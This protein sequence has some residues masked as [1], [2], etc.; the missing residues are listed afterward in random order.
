MNGKKTEVMVKI[1]SGLRVVPTTT[2]ANLESLESY[3]KYQDIE[4]FAQPSKK[5]HSRCEA[6]KWGL[7]ISSVSLMP[8][9]LYC[10][11]KYKNIVGTTGKSQCRRVNTSHGRDTLC[12]CSRM[13]LI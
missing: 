4:E 6:L 12:A 1:V 11:L 8:T 9:F 10:F 13:V 3:Y 5:G 2:V 7:F